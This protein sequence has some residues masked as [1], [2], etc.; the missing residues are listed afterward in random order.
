MKT[1]FYRPGELGTIVF[2]TVDGYGVRTDGNSLPVISRVILPE[3]I[4][5][6]GYLTLAD[7]YPQDMVKLDTGLFY[8]RFTVPPGG[9]SVGTY[10]FD[11]SYSDPIDDILKKIAYNI[12]VQSVSGNIGLKVTQ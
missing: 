3:F 4:D 11:I 9:D 6:D 7:G 12:T 10:I 5:E 2:E 8:Y 1:L